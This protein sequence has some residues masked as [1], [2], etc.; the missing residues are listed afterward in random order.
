[1]YVAKQ[2]L[3]QWETLSAI[4]RA[5]AMAHAQEVPPAIALLGTEL[6]A[7]AI[8]LVPPSGDGNGHR[9]AGCDQRQ[10]VLVLSAA[11]RLVAQADVCSQGVRRSN[12]EGGLYAQWVRS[13]F[14]VASPGEDAV[15]AQDLGIMEVR[16]LL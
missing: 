12:N 9:I 7:A 1:M 14:G 11:L 13:C 2:P 15:A 3:L 8:N 5:A 10:G 4:V 6:A 16:S